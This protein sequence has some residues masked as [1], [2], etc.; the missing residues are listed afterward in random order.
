MTKV[1]KTNGFT[2]EK[3]AKQLISFEGFKL[4]VG[5]PG[6]IDGFWEWHVELFFWFEGKF[7]QSTI[8]YDGQKYGFQHIID[9]LQEEK[10]GCVVIFEH[11]IPEDETVY[12]CECIV[13][14]IYST[15]THDWTNVRSENWTVQQV[16]DKTWKYYFKTFKPKQSTFDP[17]VAAENLRK[18]AAKSK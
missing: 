14:E 4:P 12:M 8:P 13:T 15:K 9:A 18:N 3:R 7:I 5:S 11:N 17:D 10:F 2:N 6:D 1:S 16:F